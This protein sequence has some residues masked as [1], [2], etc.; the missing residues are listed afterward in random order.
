MRG[1][2][3]I[4]SNSDTV[5]S[6]TRD[7]ISPRALEVSTTSNEYDPII[8]GSSASFEDIATKLGT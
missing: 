1:P 3:G 6:Y 2:I 7:N 5:V 8:A 4:S